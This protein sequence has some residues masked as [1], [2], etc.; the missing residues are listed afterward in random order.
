LTRRSA[1]AK[2]SVG[3]TSEQVSAWAVDPQQLAAKQRLSTKGRSN[4]LRLPIE[5]EIERA[6]DDPRMIRTRLM[7]ADKV[8]PIQREHR[9][10]VI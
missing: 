6:D 10:R 5:I 9:S 4:S 3:A 7:Q 1:P 2:Y 8:F